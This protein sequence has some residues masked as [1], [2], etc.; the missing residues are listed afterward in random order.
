MEFLLLKTFD[1]ADKRLAK[2]V[3]DMV[4]LIVYVY[5]IGFL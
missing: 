5:Y 2:A 4:S 3:L 1:S